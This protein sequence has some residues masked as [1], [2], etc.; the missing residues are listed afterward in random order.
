MVKLVGTVG[1]VASHT[2]AMAA[3]LRA[4]AAIPDTAPL[5]QRT[6]SFA[7]QRGELPATRAT[8]ASQWIDEQVFIAL[9][10]DPSHHLLLHHHHQPP[11]HT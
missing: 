9:H 1:L 3:P 10:G 8:E 5:M 11:E 6:L 7:V 2:A 4:V